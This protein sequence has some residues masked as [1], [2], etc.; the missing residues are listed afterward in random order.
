MPEDIGSLRM[1][2]IS[3]LR[4]RVAECFK[5]RWARLCTVFA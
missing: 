1:P 4:K 2:F 3:L 5:P